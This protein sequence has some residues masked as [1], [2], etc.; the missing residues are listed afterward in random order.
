MRTQRALTRASATMLSAL[1][2][3]FASKAAPAS[4][5]GF[6]AWVEHNKH[7]VAH[8]GLSFICCYTAMQLVNSRRQAEMDESELREQVRDATL[9]RKALLQRLPALARETGLPA[10]S[11]SKFEAGLAALVMKIDEDPEK[12]VQ[13][14]LKRARADM[15]EKASS[16]SES[17]APKGQ[18]VW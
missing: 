6:S 3:G 17:K 2:R 9:A 1:R 14:D 18:A 5:G 15:P 11:A 10:K 7:N 8:M 12:A 16:T 4:G 13:E